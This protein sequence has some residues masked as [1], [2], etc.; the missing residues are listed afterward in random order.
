MTVETHWPTLPKGP[1]N[2]PNVLLILTDDVGYGACSTFGGSIETPCLDELAKNGLSFTQFHTT[3]MCSPTRASMLTGRNPHNVQMGRVAS[4]P[5]GVD[6]YTSVIPRSAGTIPKILGQNGYST[7]MFGKSHLTPDWEMGPL[8]PYDRWPTGLG[9]DYFWGFLGFDTNQ[10]APQLVENTT[11]VEPPTDRP[12]QHFDGMMA[13]KAIEWIGQQ[14]AVY[15]DRPFFAYYSTGTAH[16]PHHAP[17][18]WIEK[19]K[20]PFD[21]GWDKLRE[22]I[23]ERQKRAKVIPE[24]ARLN[25]RNPQIPA[26]DTLSPDHQAVAARQ[27]EVYA[28]QLSYCDHEVGRV[29]DALKEMGEFDNTLVLFIQGDNGSSAEAGMAGVVYEQSLHNGY[30]EDFDYIHSRIDDFG[31]PDV[32]GAYSAGWSH[33]MNTPFQYYKQIASH[34]G[35]TR[36]GLV[37]HWP[38]GFGGASGI[39][40][41]FHH[42]S[43]I[44]PTILDAAN[45]AAPQVIDGVEQDPID[46]IS[47]L[48]A[49]ESDGVSKRTTQVFELMENF[50]IYHEGWFAN[51]IPT[52][53]IDSDLTTRKPSGAIED[54]E[55]QLFYIEED[56]SQSVDLKHEHPEKLRELQELFWKQAAKEKIL[57]L[58]GGNEYT[59]GKPRLMAGRDSAV[60]RP[61][62]KRLFHEAAPSTVGR[63]FEIESKIQIGEDQGNGVLFCQ[64]S[65]FSGYS[66]YMKDGL[67]NFY[68]NAVPPY[69]FKVSA[70]KQLEPGAHVVKLRFDIDEAKVHSGG[71]ATIIVD[72]EVLAIGRIGR[73]LRTFS[74]QDGLSVGCDAVSAISPDYTI[75]DSVFD[76]S[77]SHATIRLL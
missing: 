25:P 45:V 60:F 66:L 15:P 33:A 58:H 47:M 61:G 52:Q 54:R 27:M 62:V 76:G 51:V 38:A 44:L 11:F 30:K 46:G 13:D 26:W 34:F 71:E 55:W 67:L 37:M 42:V 74:N 5:T 32:A 77:I 40:T 29:L 41:Q 31:G 39:R 70:K 8:G 73:T 14:R 56:Y 57:P 17:K 59:A 50:A 53:S 43:D 9:F 69:C 35:G 2:A 16:C 65:N 24:S 63:S 3:A 36:N 20:G 18:E 10:W 72:G 6:G 75:P 68:Y 49:K 21:V 22:E 7:A 64:G 12:L 1:A 48:Y 28:A 23:F 4:R 19:Y